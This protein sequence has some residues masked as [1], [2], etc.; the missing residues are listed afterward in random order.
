MYRERK[1]GRR[2]VGQPSPS[3]VIKG[4]K[5]KR[6]GKKKRKKRRGPRMKIIKRGEVRGER[7][8]S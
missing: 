3:L 8:A 7:S 2:G 6:V 1:E 4:G 5:R